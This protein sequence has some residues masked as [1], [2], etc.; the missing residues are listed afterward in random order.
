LVAAVAIAVVLW[1]FALWL[2]PELLGYQF[3][4]GIFSHPNCIMA[5][6]DFHGGNANR[7]QAFY[8]LFHLAEYRKLKYFAIPPVWQAW[9][10]K[11]YTAEAISKWPV[12]VVPSESG[13]GC[14]SVF[15]K[16][17]KQHVRDANDVCEEWHQSN[18]F[19]LNWYLSDVLKFRFS[20]W[21]Y[22]L[23]DAADHRQKASDRIANLKAVNPGKEIVTVHKRFLD[24]W[25]ST[26]INVERLPMYDLVEQYCH[27]IPAAVEDILVNQAGFKMSQVKV[28]VSTDH[29]MKEEEKLFEWEFESDSMPFIANMWTWVLSDAHLG[30]PNSTIDQTACRFRR[31]LCHEAGNST[32]TCR[33]CYPAELHE[34]AMQGALR[35]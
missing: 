26:T 15:A 32:S 22:L 28:V 20:Y 17:A 18:L 5:V 4:K 1:P 30:H 6:Q 7:I 19:R 9:V 31:I 10:C 12:K 25:C 33:P 14:P 35:W 2:R 21:K 8:N 29:Y 24:V 11:L 34:E 27:L 13:E 3:H 23:P 16:I